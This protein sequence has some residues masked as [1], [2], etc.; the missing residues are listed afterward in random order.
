QVVHAV[1][2]SLV[3]LFLLLAFLLVL[4]RRWLAVAA[5]VIVLTLILHGDVGGGDWLAVIPA[6]LFAAI[7]LAGLTRF[8]LVAL[9]TASLVERLV[10]R[11]PWTLEGGAWYAWQAWLTAAVL[12]ALLAFAF[13]AATAGAAFVSRPLT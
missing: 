2:D 1:L 9:A 10:L 7:V 11:T 8:G 3:A 4:R 12:L 5:A 6:G 13:R